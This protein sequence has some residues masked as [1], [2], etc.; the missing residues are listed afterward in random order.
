MGRA[1]LGEPGHRR[2]GCLAAHLAPRPWARVRSE[3]RTRVARLQI[4]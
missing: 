1:S 2:E 3:S 4:G